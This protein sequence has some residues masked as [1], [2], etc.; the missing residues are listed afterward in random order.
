MQRQ[1]RPHAAVATLTLL[2]AG[3]PAFAQVTFKQFDPCCLITGMSAD[4]S[5][6]VGNSGGGSSQNTF[7]WTAAGGVEMIGVSGDG[8][9]P[10]IS[11]DGRTIVAGMKDAAGHRHAAIWQGGKE[12]K[13]LTPFAGA[14]PDEVGDVSQPTGVSADGSIIVGRVSL[15]DA[16]FAA[17]RWDAKNGMVNLGTLEEGSV[18]GYAHGVSADGRMIFGFDFKQGFNPAGRNGVSMNSRRGAMWWD[19]KERLLHPFGWAGEAW[20]SNDVGSIIVGQFHPIDANNT[21]ITG[22]ATTYKWTA[23]DGH[24]EDLGAVDIPIGGDNRNYLSEPLAMSDDGSV[25]GGVTGW[26]D[27]FAMIWTAQTG[28]IYVTDF[29]TMNGVTE[30]LKWAKFTETVYISPDG[31]TIVGHAYKD[32]PSLTTW[33]ITVK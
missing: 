13:F 16:R 6:A 22:A 18:D 4:G 14:V 11:R 3:G 9:S 2:V 30:H 26:Q 29:L 8:G 10:V 33:I 28:M 21:I 25:V 20:A 32:F 12:W 23:W 7:R 5:V 19:G 27:K 31:R 15:A 1:S 24:F 17:F